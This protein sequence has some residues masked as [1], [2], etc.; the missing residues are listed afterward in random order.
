MS[1]LTE[2]RFST[3]L[4]HSICWDKFLWLKSMRT[5]QS[6]TD[7]ENWKQG[8]YLKSLFRYC[9]YSSL[10]LHQNSTWSSF[11]KFSCNVESEPSQW[12]ICILLTWNQFYYLALWVVLSSMRSFITLYIDPF[13][14]IRSLVQAEFA[15][16]NIFPYTIIKKITSVNIRT[17]SSKKI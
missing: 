13:E 15:N 5:I 7:K 6:L 4:L 3:M 1:G 17:R 9:G 14:N 11:W 2:D 8:K 16:V 12:N 10:I